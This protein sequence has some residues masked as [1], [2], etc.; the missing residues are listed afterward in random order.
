ME[1]RES[2]RIFRNRQSRFVHQL[3]DGEVCQQ[4]TIELLPYQFRGFAAQDNL[5][6]PE[7]GLQFV[8]QLNHILPI[9]CALL[10][11]RSTT[12]FILCVRTACRWSGCT[13]YT[14]KP[15]MSCGAPTAD[16]WRCRS[17]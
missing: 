1:K 16:R 4:K 9:N 5:T 13:N 7:M 14:T 6:P 2:V 12:A 17:G 15:A 8:K 10:K 3:A 11:L